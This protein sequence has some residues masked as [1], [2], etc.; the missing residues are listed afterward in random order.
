VCYEEI[1]CPRC[2]SL[3]V[4]KN[5]TTANGK[6]KYQCTDCRRQFITDYTYRACQSF[7]RELIV[8]MTMNSS[9][10]RDIARVL[11]I[12]TQTVMKTIR[13]SA[14]AV[15][16]PRVPSRI[17]DLE[18]D[19]CW[20]FVKDKSRQCWCWYGLNRATTRIAAYV[21]GRRTDA[22][23]RQLSD[24]LAGCA[25]ENFYTDDWQSYAKIL[26]GERHTISKA[27]TLNIERHNLNFR[28]HLK[29]LHRRTICFS[30]S[31]EMHAAVIKL[32][33]NHVNAY[34]HKL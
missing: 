21:L 12:S 28:T 25:V 9:G 20:S 32:Y 7:I 19:E 33:V 1:A 26:P 29:R 16:E 3:H 24:K 27:E 2:A 15:R 34:Q 8:P 4:K 5:G 18:I 17:K 30:K 31:A 23:C 11:S 14:A 6:Q 10:I 13:A 22:S